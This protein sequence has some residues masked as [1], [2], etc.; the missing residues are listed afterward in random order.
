MT[1]RLTTRIKSLEDRNRSLIL[2]VD[3][4]IQQQ[5]VMMRNQTISIRTI[6]LL[7]SQVKDLRAEIIR[8]ELEQEIE[9]DGI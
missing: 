1:Q 3:K 2:A 9:E 4:L 5:T 8:K 6:S 7:A